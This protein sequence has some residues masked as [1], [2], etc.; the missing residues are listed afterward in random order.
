MSALSISTVIDEAW[1]M[2]EKHIENFGMLPK[3]VEWAATF[4]PNQLLKIGAGMKG[5]WNSK[6]AGD[7]ATI[8][9]RMLG[10]T[11][12]E[13]KG[14]IT[15]I[16]KRTFIAPAPMGSRTAIFLQKLDGKAGADVDILVHGRNGQIVQT[17]K[18]YFPE[19]DSTPTKNVLVGDGRFGFV[20]VEIDAKM[21]GLRF[22]KFAYQIKY[23]ERPVT[24]DEKPVTGFADLHVHQV[25]EY[26]YLGNWL[27]GSHAGPPREALPPCNSAAHAI[28]QTIWDGVLMTKPADPKVRHGKG[29]PTYDDWP[30]HLDIA[31]QQVHESWLKAAHE[32]GLNLIIACPVNNEPFALIMAALH[33]QEAQG[34]FR[35]MPV[36]KEEIARIHD[37]AKNHDWYEVA[38][39][40]WEARKIIHAGKLAVVISVECS[41]LFPKDQGDYI[42]QLDELYNLGVRCVQIVH[43][44]DSRFA[45][46]ALSDKVLSIF[47]TLKR[48]THTGVL[49]TPSGFGFTK[50][51]NGQNALGL[52]ED[53]EKLLNA[54]M[55]RHMLVDTAHYSARALEGA[56]AIALRRQRY[57]L[58]NSHTKFYS[59]LTSDVQDVWREFVTF[60]NQIRFFKET[61]G[62]IGLRT[63]PWVNRQAPRPNRKPIAVKTD[64]G[65][66][67]T[68]RSYAQ[69]VTYAADNDVPMAF[70]SD[71]NGWINQLGP[72]NTEGTKP[73][74]V[75]SEYWTH[76]FHHIGMLPEVL[77]DLIALKTPG[78]SDLANSAEAFLSRWERTWIRTSDDVTSPSSAKPVATVPRRPLQS[79]PRAKEERR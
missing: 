13:G 43:E 29:F 33:P 68:A 12:E 71:I 8:G 46:A 47:E 55:D 79:E 17:S 23:V 42:Q 6:A 3:D 20:T 1:D 63:G 41:N 34:A 24:D 51:A 37:F 4:I 2:F 36:I 61:G 67:G 60:D 69:Q 59:V 53:G 66:I 28:P 38:L 77:Q 48:V 19:D 40:P 26:A 32:R 9:P 39:T 65:D 76:G 62:I 11:F 31:H 64:S 5:L 45:G 30:H 14:T 35:D 21:P 49:A 27:H 15:K 56:F 75:S 78:A 50:D 44:V 74:N 16:G 73:A 52:T 25:A 7:W 10:P 72:R 22:D 57:P 54:L 70:G 58:I 18:M